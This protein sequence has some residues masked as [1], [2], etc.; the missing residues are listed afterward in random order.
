MNQEAYDASAVTHVI[1]GEGEEPAAAL[2]AGGADRVIRLAGETRD[3][4]KLLELVA[5]RKSVVVWPWP[6][7]GR[8]NG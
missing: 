5:S 7:G 4:R 1:V 6:E 3:A 2:L 8:A